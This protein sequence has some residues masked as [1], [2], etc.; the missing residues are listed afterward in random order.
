MC[1]FFLQ[2]FFLLLIVIY[3]VGVCVVP[4]FLTVPPT[5][6]SSMILW[7][8]STS[9]PQPRTPRLPGDP[10]APPLAADCVGMSYLDSYCLLYLNVNSWT[11]VI[12]GLS[13]FPIGPFFFR[14][15]EIIWFIP[16]L[17][18]FFDLVHQINR[19]TPENPVRKN[20]KK[21]VI[22]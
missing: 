11:W 18:I 13:S 6:R 7:D 20:K 9:E 21:C 12:Q 8:K 22:L 5:C 14:I 17:Q 4:L 1:N 2:F 3:I 15:C 10:A 16:F 19:R